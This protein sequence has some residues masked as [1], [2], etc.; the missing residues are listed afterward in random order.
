MYKPLSRLL[1]LAVSIV[2]FSCQNDDSIS[3]PDYGIES[4]ADF[5]I[6]SQYPN[7]WI[8]EGKTIYNSGTTSRTI[9][10]FEYYQNGYIK[11]ARRYSPLPTDHLY[12]EVSRGEDNQP[13][14]SKY[15]TPEGTV[16]FETR[17]DQGLPEVKK[18]YSE[19]GVAIHTYT[20]GVLSSIEFTSADTRNQTRITY[21]QN[22]GTRKVRITAD[23][24]ILLEETYP[25]ADRVGTGFYSRNYVPVAAAFD[26]VQTV[27]RDQNWGKSVL[28][29][30][31]WEYELNAFNQLIY[32]EPE[33][34]KALNMELA[35]SN[36]MYQSIIE[37][38]PVTENGVLLAGGYDLEAFEEFDPAFGLSAA[39]ETLKETESE[40]FD[41]KYGQEIVKRVNF[42]K[43][44]ILI[45]AIRNLPTDEATAERV[46]SIAYK[47]MQEIQGY[48]FAMM[49]DN[50]ITL[51]PGERGDGLTIEER[52]ILDKVWFEVKFF[53]NLKQHQSGIILNTEA[54]YKKALNEVNEAEFSVI[55]K[56][57]LQVEAY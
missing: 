40:H 4:D 29:S 28:S 12:M 46:K 47:R 18:Y 48:T 33:G 37:Q 25:I 53:S 1:L 49:Q 6:T 19:A 14:W 21:D 51:I 42:G 22:A 45:G 31:N 43:N 52:A 20:A 55:H 5:Q 9:A 11:S 39:L 8:K 44:Y 36:P 13:L 41:L 3:Q 56:A 23:G 54:Q 2:I 38:Y 15:Y 26:P 50:T 57:Y 24:E 27:Y 7:G 30:T 34:F 17:Y 35:A 32:P 10:E 16:W